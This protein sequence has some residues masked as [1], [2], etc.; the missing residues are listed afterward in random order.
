MT[1]TRA[2]ILAI[3]ATLLALAPA[4]EAG[5][6]AEPSHILIMDDLSRE[7]VRLTG[8]SAESIYAQGDDGTRVFDGARTLA[9]VR[10]D[11][12]ISASGRGRARTVVWLVDGRRLSGTLGPWNPARDALTLVLDRGE[13]VAIGLDLVRAVRTGAVTP[14]ARTIAP[15]STLASGTD[16]TITDDEAVLANGDR[17]RGFVVSISD[18]ALV[19]EVA[20]QRRTIELDLLDALLLASPPRAPQAMTIW[21]TEGAVLG[22]SAVSSDPDAGGVSLRWTLA[23]G[24]GRAIE[25]TMTPW[26]IRAALLQPGRL[27]ALGTPVRYAPTGDRRWAPAPIIEPADGAP[28]GAGSVMLLGPTEVAWALPRAADRVAFDASLI[29][30][31]SVWADCELVVLVRLSRREAPVEIHRSSLRRNSPSVRLALDLPEPQRADRE[32]LI[33][34]EPGANGPVHDDVRIDLPLLRIRR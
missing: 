21:T 30:A 23:D 26:M 22:V 12:E 27:V 11:S 5:A 10:I 6:Q 18:D 4:P 1:R 32:L 24:E 34:V 28:L 25:S 33:R 14:E 2:A 3:I 20:G 13:R 29:D 7:R 15:V 19:M 31:T 8:F 16:R 9:I 17:I